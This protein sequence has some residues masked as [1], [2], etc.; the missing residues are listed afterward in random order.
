MRGRHRRR[1]ARRQHARGDRRELVRPD[2]DAA[3]RA[4][5]RRTAAPS[6]PAAGTCGPQRRSCPPARPPLPCMRGTAAAGRTAG[7]GLQQRQVLLVVDLAGRQ[8][9][10]RLEVQQGC[11][12]DQ[13][14]AG[15]IQVPAAGQ[16]ADVADELVGHARQRDLGD[17]ELVLGDQPSSRSNGPSKTSRCTSEAACGRRSA[18][19]PGSSDSPVRHRWPS[20]PHVL[21]R[22]RRATRL[23]SPA[24]SRSASTTASASRTIRPRSTEIP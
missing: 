24:A 19:D 7:P 21:A 5:A 22:S 10:R 9:P 15:L 12:D 14:V 23:S 2:P 3:P 17:V 1:P 8:Q 6:A 16:R 13:E 18:I 11:G 20:L 4:A